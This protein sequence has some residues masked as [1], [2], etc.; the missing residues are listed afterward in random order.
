[1]SNLKID[2]KTFQEV[3]DIAKSQQEDQ[4][5]NI[6]NLITKRN[7]IVNLD[8]PIMPQ[9]TENFVKWKNTT[10]TPKPIVRKWK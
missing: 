5:L 1:M 4:E 10:D 2:F 3:L 8:S 7:G 6:S 9:T